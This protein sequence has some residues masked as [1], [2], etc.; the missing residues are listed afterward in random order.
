MWLRYDGDPSHHIRAVRQNLNEVFTS[1]W[2]C[3]EGMMQWPACSLD[4]NTIT[5][6]TWGYFIGIV[7]AREALIYQHFRERIA[8]AATIIES[9]Q[10]F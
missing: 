7:H 1:R 3:R 4:L 9:N 6:S 2:T 5:Y 8:I 10:A